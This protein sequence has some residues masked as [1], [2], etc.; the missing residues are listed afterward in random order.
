M[1]AYLINRSVST[2]IGKKTA[3][4]VWF[5]SPANYSFL[6]IFGCP[7]YVHVNNGKLE[8]WSIKCI[9]LGFKLGIKGYKLY[10]P[11]DWK[12]IFNRDVIFDE[13]SLLKISK[14]DQVP[15]DEKIQIQVQKPNPLHEHVISS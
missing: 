4:E 6:K 12:I 5:G 7:A 10:H 9:F 15:N 3:Q 1:V 8:P 11:E 13:S 2:A 14:S